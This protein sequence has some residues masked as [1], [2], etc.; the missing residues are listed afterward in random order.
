MISEGLSMEIFVK[1]IVLFFLKKEM[2][3]NKQNALYSFFFILF[4]I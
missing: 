3:N 4:S 1:F 2:K